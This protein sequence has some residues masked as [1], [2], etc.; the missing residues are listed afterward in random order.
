[1]LLSDLRDPNRVV[2]RTAGLK[3]EEYPLLA[4][5]C[6][7]N[8]VEL[9]FLDLTDPLRGLGFNPLDTD[10]A[11][12]AYDVIA[13]VRR[14]VVNPLSNDSEFWGEERPRLPRGR[15]AR[16]VQIVPRHARPVRGAERGGRCPA[17]RMRARDSQIGGVVSPQRVAQRRDGALHRD[18]WPTRSAAPPHGP[19]RPSHE[20]GRSDLFRRRR[21]IAIRCPEPKLSVMRPAYNLLIQ[22]LLD[23]AIET[24]DADPHDLSRPAASF[25]IEDLPAWGAIPGLVDRLA[26]LRSRR[27]CVNAAIQSMGQLRCAHGSN[28]RPWRSHSLIRCCCRASTKRTR[29]TSAARQRDTVVTLTPASSLRV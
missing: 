5:F 17:R 10:D 11:D 12:C 19:R 24:A 22:W 4:A 16:R 7:E 23:L 25:F 1:M 2:V 9:L 6:R 14:L 29:N 27:I 26:T 8:D 3:A 28:P 20:L 18:R 15:V 13:S 21:V